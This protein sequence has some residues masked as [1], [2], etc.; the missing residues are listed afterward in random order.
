MVF[1]KK[2]RGHLRGLDGFDLNSGSPFLQMV[3]KLSGFCVCGFSKLITK[4]IGKQNTY[5][6]CCRF[7]CG[8]IL[9]STCSI[10]WHSLIVVLVTNLSL[11]NKEVSF[12]LLFYELI[13]LFNL[14]NCIETTE[15][16][17]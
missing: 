7:H 12:M 1:Q 4:V 10:P 6:K 14:N 2:G 5:R 8:I 17:A 15:W 9:F 16:K 3:M 13:L 11:V